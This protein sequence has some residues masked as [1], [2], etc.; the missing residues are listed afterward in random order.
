M[1]AVAATLA[2][3]AAGASV[4]TLR[5]FNAD[6]LISAYVTNSSFDDA[7]MLKAGLGEDTGFVDVTEFIRPGDNNVLFTDFNAAGGWSYGFDFRK[8]GVTFDY[9]MC[10]V[11]GVSS[12]GNDLS[13]G[14]V[15]S[16]DPKIP[17]G[18]VPEATTWA[19]MILGFGLTGAAARRRARLALP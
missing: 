5:L 13:V 4:Y 19:M 18:A 11:A 2:P 10:G 14:L 17:N 7:L 8:D 1:A 9:G 15:F 16:Q 12:C 6:D 3:A